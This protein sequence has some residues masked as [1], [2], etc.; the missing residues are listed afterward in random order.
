M[1]SRIIISLLSTYYGYNE[2]H[3]CRL[4]FMMECANDDMSDLV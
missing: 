3:I 1:L 4:N 2:R